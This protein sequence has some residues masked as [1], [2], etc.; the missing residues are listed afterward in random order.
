MVCFLYLAN[1]HALSHICCLICLLA[2]VRELGPRCLGR[3]GGSVQISR[4]LYRVYK[5]VEHK[6]A[7]SDTTTDTGMV[8]LSTHDQRFLSRWN[9]LVMC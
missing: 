1:K 2:T 8:I 9:W 3:G 4:Q 7:D 6:T 5:N